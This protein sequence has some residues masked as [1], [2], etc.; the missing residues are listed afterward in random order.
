MTLNWL[1]Y[2]IIILL[3]YFFAL[4]QNSFFPH[5]LLFG[6]APDLIFAFFFVLIFFENNVKILPL[7]SYSVAGGFFADIFLHSGFGG[8]IILFMAIGF[9]LRW[10]RSFL[11]QTNKGSPYFQFLALFF[12]SFLVYRVLIMAFLFFLD[13]SNFVFLIDWRLFSAIFYSAVFASV[14]FWVYAKFISIIDGRRQLFLFKEDK[15]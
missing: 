6:S 10:T 5:F 7:I 1:R 12:A 3:F 13:T 9:L 8:S 14:L 4:L 15:I 2:S 11:A